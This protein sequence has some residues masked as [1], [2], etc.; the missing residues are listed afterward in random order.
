MAR[1]KLPCARAISHPLGAGHLDEAV[2]QAARGVQLAVGD[3][4]ELRGRAHQ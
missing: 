2:A 3:Q 1:M 4:Q